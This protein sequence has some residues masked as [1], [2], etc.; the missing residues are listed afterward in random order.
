MK[1]LMIF[2]P[3]L[4]IMIICCLFETDILYAQADREVA[5]PNLNFTRP[6]DLQH[7]ND[8]SNRLFV[9]EQEGIIYTFENN[10][11][12]NTKKVFLDI[13]DQVNDSGNEQGLLGL[14]FHPDYQNNGYF[15]VDYTAEDPNR[16]VISRYQ[17]STSNPD[18]AVKESEFVILEVNQPYSNH[19]AGQIVFDSDGYFYITLGDGGSGGDPQGNGQNLETLLGSILRIDVDQTSAGLNYAIPADNPFVGNLRGFREEIYAYGLR[20]PWRIS[21]DL[22]T[23]WLWAA[24]VGQD[25]YEEINIIEKGKNYGWNITEGFHCYNAAACDTTG[26]ILPVWEYSHSA[27]QSITGGYV[28]RGADVPELTGRY[29]Y[30]DYVSGRIWALEY[31][32][33]GEPV[34]SLLNDTDLNISSFGVDRNNELYICAFDGKIYRFISTS[35]DVLESENKITLKKYRLAQNY[36]NPFNS[37][38]IIQYHLK[39]DTKVVME[40]Y[41]IIG[42]LIKILVNGTQPQGNQTVVWDGTDM[43]NNPVKSGVYLYR[44]KGDGFEEIRKMLIL[45]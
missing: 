11:N 4:L 27:G 40:I 30:A 21:F 7:P 45:N 15:Y 29:I 36:P 24:D 5:F 8:D 41:D 6:V 42:K 25:A 23:Q 39:S 13:R 14:V 37:S 20:N 10:R 31:D 3:G 43:K 34:N 19:N 16:T 38:T 18:S 44:L 9:V 1:I 35:T 26:L 12:V 22:K 28:Y 2:V 33:T 32:G 17:V